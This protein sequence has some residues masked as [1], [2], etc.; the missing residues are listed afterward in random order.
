MLSDSIVDPHALCFTNGN[1]G[2]CIN[3]QS[4][5]QDALTTFKGIQYAVYYDAGRHVCL[6]RRPVGKDAW[7]ILRFADHR[8][9]GNDSHNVAVIGVCPADG[10]IHLAFD[11]HGGPLHYRVSRPGIATRPAEL[12]WATNLFGP[13]TSELE[14]GKP[15]ERVTYPRFVRTPGGG[16][17]FGYRIGA[18]GAGDKCLANYDPKTHTWTKLGAF[19]A[20]QGRYGASTTR[21]AYLNGLTF[22]AHGRLHVT[23][24]WRE[25]SDPMTNHDLDY[26][27]SND[28][29]LT[30]FNS[31]GSACGQRGTQPMT[32]DSPGVRVVEIPEGRG[33]VNATT[34]AVDSRGR[35]HI[36]AVRLP[37]NV[38][39]NPSWPATRVLDQY[40]HYWRDDQGV[41]QCRPLNF[42]GAR[43]QLV[44]DAADTAWLVY[45]GNRRDPSPPTLSIAAARAEGAWSDWKALRTER[46]PFIGDA[47]VDRYQNPGHLSIYVQESPKPVLLTNSPL[48]VFTFRTSS[49]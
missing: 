25:S 17:L 40:F 4:F 11:H 8:L 34:Q 45:T 20:G 46:G 1:W 29:G 12:A 47:L 2:I 3:G 36:I 37:D 22:D 21:N 23:W 16:L 18:S 15:L 9:I 13:I 26:A 43:P 32:I 5:Q 27:W 6:A 14:T 49:P 39:A 44:F 38:A 42:G 24:C 28:T 31:P 41:W 10:T 30:W 33:L 48:H 7:E 19:A 35:I